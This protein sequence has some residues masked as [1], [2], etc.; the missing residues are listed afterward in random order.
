MSAY[1]VY[2]GKENNDLYEKFGSN[3]SDF[4][5]DSQPTYKVFNLQKGNTY[6]LKYRLKNYN[7]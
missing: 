1:E 3:N 7:G 5:H 4:K 2:I 6:Y